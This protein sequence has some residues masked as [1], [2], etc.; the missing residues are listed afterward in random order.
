ME[1]CL[2]RAVTELPAYMQANFTVLEGSE[3]YT[4]EMYIPKTLNEN[5]H[6]NWTVYYPDLIE[7][8]SKEIPAIVINN[9]FEALADGRRP[10][11]QPDYTTYVY[12]EGEVVTAIKLLPE[13]KLE[14]SFDTI[15]NFEEIEV[16]GYLIPENGTPLLRFVPTIDNVNSKVYFKIEAL[17]HFRC[18]GAMGMGFIDTVVARVKYMPT[19]IAP[20]FYY[21]GNILTAKLSE[22]P[23]KYVDKFLQLKKQGMDNSEMYIIGNSFEHIGC[24]T[25]DNIYSMCC[26]GY[27]R[28]QNWGLGQNGDVIYFYCNQAMIDVFGEDSL[29]EITGS[30]FTGNGWYKYYN[31]ATHS[32]ESNYKVEKQESAPS[33][34]FSLYGFDLVGNVQAGI[35]ATEFADIFQDLF[36]TKT[37]TESPLLD[38]LVISEGTIENVT[39]KIP[40]G[41]VVATLDGVDPEITYTMDFIDGDNDNQYFEIDSQS[42]TIVAKDSIPE[43]SSAT[44]IY[45]NIQV[46]VTDT[47]SGAK[48]SN[49]ITVGE[50]QSIA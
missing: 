6:G 16:N 14:L 2:C 42:N 21:M 48:V 37:I 45:F 33:V 47:T 1:Q 44:A 29:S 17:K 30:W 7:D 20:T 49:N 41:K 4:G 3:I 39:G 9:S 23:T 28:G 38:A 19:E 26:F 50:A 11:G 35:K 40:S 8:V 32:G 24:E 22:N 46:K 18:G 36:E 13:I 43:N 5:L 25:Y 15:Q 10:D 27:A 12:E 31:A 34:S